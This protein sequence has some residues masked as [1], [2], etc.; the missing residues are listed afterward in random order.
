MSALASSESDSGYAHVAYHVED[1]VAHVRLNRPDKLN[2][3]GFGPDGSRAE[4][5]AALQRA[6]ADASVGAILVSAEGRLPA[7]GDLTGAPPT[8]RPYRHGD[9]CGGRPVPRR[10]PSRPQADRRGRARP[11][12]GGGLGLLQ[13]DLVVA[14]E[15][16][17]FGLVEGRI[18][19]SGATELVP[20]IGPARAQF[21][22][23]T[24]ELID[25]SVAERIG[26]VL[27]VV[28]PDAL[29]VRAGDLAARIAATPREAAILNKAAVNATADAMG[30][31]RPRGRAYPRRGDRLERPLRRS[32]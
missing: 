2:V 11:V 16:A 27:A 18:G 6:D 32:S 21:L 30:H 20:L 1:G 26:L 13:F 3:L 7:G 28:A 9:G 10:H 24:G 29:S 5:L 25:A 19:H 15:D 12:P 23:L 8:D 14:A 22:I 31:R 17:R 4:I